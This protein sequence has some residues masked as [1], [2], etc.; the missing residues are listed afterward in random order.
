MVMKASLPVPSWSSRYRGSADMV[1]AGDTDLT[2]IHLSLCL[3][4]LLF[5]VYIVVLDFV[6]VS[7][8]LSF[9]GAFCSQGEPSPNL[10]FK[11]AFSYT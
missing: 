11:K 1:A 6:I 9:P 4:L 7:L 8:S 3:T 2:S 5:V 10:H